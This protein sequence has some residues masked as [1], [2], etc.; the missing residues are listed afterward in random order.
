[1]PADSPAAP[2]ASSLLILLVWMV[3]GATALTYWLRPIPAGDLPIRRAG[4]QIDVNH[5]SVDALCLL[6]GIGPQLARRIIDHRTAS[7]SFETVAQLQAVSGIGQ[8][9]ITRIKALAR[10]GVAQRQARAD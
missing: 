3:L 9:T 4:I 10:C 7:G 5:A 8:Q 6:P 1:M 2:I